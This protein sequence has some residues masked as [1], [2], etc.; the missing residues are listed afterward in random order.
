MQSVLQEIIVGNLFAVMLIFMRLGMALMMMPGIG[1]SFVTPQVRLLFALALSLVVTPVLAPL[2][3]G[4]PAQST[5]FVML[6]ASEAF[7]GIFIGTVMRIVMSALDTAGSIISLQSG[8]SSALL[9]NPVS[10]SQGSLIG[11]I[12]S[13]L[14]VTLLLVMNLHHYMLA[15]VVDSYQ[16]FPAIGALPDMGSMAEVISRTVTVAFK[17]GVQIAMPFLIVGLIMQIGF[18][19]LGRLMPQ[20]QI[21]F[22]ALPAQI[23]V[24]LI[25]LTMV[26]SAGMLF[27]V[28]GYE[29]IVTGALVP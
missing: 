16:I 23:A 2:L 28:S 11:S 6:L 1:D 7:I 20:I 29:S 18:G 12:Y 17:I 27:W 21:F 3:P 10:D 8:Y 26:L 24:G 14:G 5:A 15:T 4:I 19:V 13:M 9:F 25:M 22:L